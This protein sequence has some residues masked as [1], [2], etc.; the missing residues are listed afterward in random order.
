MKNMP[1]GGTYVGKEAIFEEYF[2]K[3]FSSFAEFH[4]TADEFL[5]AGDTVIVLGKYQ[6]MTKKSRKKFESPFAHVYTIKNGKITKFRQYA[7]TIKIQE[8]TRN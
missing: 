1:N 6:V 2:P 5:D 4:A 7:D 8:A 3:L